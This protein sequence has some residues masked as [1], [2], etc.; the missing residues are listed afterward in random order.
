MSC[1]RSFDSLKDEFDAKL[2]AMS[3]QDLIDAFPATDCTT[4]QLKYKAEPIA[5]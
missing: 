4:D 1:S 5:A 2:A 3:D